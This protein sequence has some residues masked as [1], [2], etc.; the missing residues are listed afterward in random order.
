MIKIAKNSLTVN[1]AFDLEELVIERVPSIKDL[2]LFVTPN[3]SWTEHVNIKCGKA[4]RCFFSL[5]RSIPYNTPMITKLQFYKSCLRSTLLLNSC[6]WQPNID[7]LRKLENVQ[8]KAIRWIC[9]LNE[10]K[11]SIASNKLLPICYQL[12]YSDLVLFCNILQN[13]Y[14]IK[15]EDDVSFYFPRPG[16]RAAHRTLF[17]VPKVCKTSTCG[18]YFIRTTANATIVSTNY[19]IDLRQEKPASAKRKLRELFLNLSISDFNPE[20]SYTFF[21]NCRCLTCRS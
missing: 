13:N 12:I 8:R 9:G 2:G 16:S 19:G 18:T 5:K 4:L 3:L 11:I 17:D 10:Y 14:D 15:V 20:N 21:I 1:M 7:S 6:I